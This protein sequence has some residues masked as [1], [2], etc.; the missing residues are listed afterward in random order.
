MGLNTVSQAPICPFVSAEET[1]LD[2]CVF[3]DV[4]VFSFQCPNTELATVVE[5]CI[6]SGGKLGIQLRAVISVTSPGDLIN[7]LGENWRSNI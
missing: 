2:A 4:S 5:N 6:Q 1:I 3:L 7:S